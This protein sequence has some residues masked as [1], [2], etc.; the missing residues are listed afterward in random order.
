LTSKLGTPAFRLL[1]VIGSKADFPF[2]RAQ[3]GVVPANEDAYL[4]NCEAE[5]SVASA[6]S[7]TASA[8][9]HGW[10]IMP[11]SARS[12]V[13]SRREFKGRRALVG[14]SARFFDLLCQLLNLRLLGREAL[15]VDNESNPRR[16]TKDFEK[17]VIWC[18][19]PGVSSGMKRAADPRKP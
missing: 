5:I 13:R 18:V 11:N 3:S 12:R 16:S 10:G 1:P 2:D 17:T 15:L 6:S 9:S 14:Y 8:S 7:S 4:A 19:S